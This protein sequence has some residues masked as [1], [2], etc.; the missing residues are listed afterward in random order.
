MRCINVKQPLA[1][2][3]GHWTPAVVLDGVSFDLAISE[4]TNQYS[5]LESFGGGPAIPYSAEHRARNFGRHKFVELGQPAL[6]PRGMGKRSAVLDVR[7]YAVVF[8]GVLETPPF[9]LVPA[10]VD[11][12]LEPARVQGAVD[13]ALVQLAFSL[14][15]VRTIL[16]LWVGRHQ[17]V[18]NGSEFL[19]N[20]ILSSEEV[21]EIEA[22]VPILPFSARVHHI[23][24][25]DLGLERM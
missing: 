3:P 9:H 4:A 12:V 7:R 22:V 21:L 6:R 11:R 16:D 17:D 25:I 2:A 15:T 23:S 13:G 14:S 5:V 18:I 8:A 20:A 19:R 24:T 10:P 1:N